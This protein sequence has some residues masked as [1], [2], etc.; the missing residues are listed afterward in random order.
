[1]RTDLRYK[2]TLAAIIAVSILLLSFLSLFL[3]FSSTLLI[4]L[5]P[6]FIFLGAFILTFILGF[7]PFLKNHMWLS[8]SAAALLSLLAAYIIHLLI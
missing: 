3:M 6:V 8:I 1:M 2:L 5:I 4:G 7:V